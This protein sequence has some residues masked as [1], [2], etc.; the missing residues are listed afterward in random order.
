MLQGLIE[1]QSVIAELTQDKLLALTRWISSAP[2]F[3]LTYP[4]LESALAMIAGLP[5]EM[6]PTPH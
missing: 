2:A 5:L 3:A 6:S 1:A 4:D